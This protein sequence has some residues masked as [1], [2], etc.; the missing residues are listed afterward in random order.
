MKWDSRSVFWVLLNT[1]LALVVIFGLK[2]LL[3]GELTFNPSRTITVSG[4]GKAVA[5]PDI[6]RISFSVVTEGKD[7][8]SVQ[9][10]NVNKMNAAIDYV[11]TQG[12]DAKD[13]K[14]SQYSLYPR[15]DYQ[16]KPLGTAGTPFIVGYTMTQTVALKVRDFTKVAN[17]LARLPEFGINQVDAVQFAVD[18]EDAY[19]NEARAEAFGKAR[20]KAEAMAKAN[21]VS[22]SKV[23]TFNESF[24]G[25]PIPVFY[26]AL[27]ADGRGGVAPAPS[28]EPGS[29]EVTVQ[30]S[31]TYAIR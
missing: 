10:E 13:I 26:K 5:V 17:I 20:A 6:A 22:I 21:G 11:K 2:F 24:G 19:L 16:V 28:L 12:I 8:Q 31:V 14:T 3:V 29:Q 1:A 30:V 4:E 15:Y 9:Q 23:V 7:P 27:E 25:G 18:D